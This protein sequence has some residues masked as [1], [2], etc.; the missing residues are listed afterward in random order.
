MLQGFRAE[1]RNRNRNLPGAA[2]GTWNLSEPVT[3]EAGGRG[4]GT[5]NLFWNLFF[6]GQVQMCNGQICNNP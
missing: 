5:W 3:V 4:T 1:R 2:V 6:Y